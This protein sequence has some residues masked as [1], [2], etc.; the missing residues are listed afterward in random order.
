[1]YI[2]LLLSKVFYKYWFRTCWF[3]DLVKFFHPWWF[4]LV[5]LSVIEIRVLKSEIILIDL[6]F[7]FL[8]Y[9]FLLHMF[10]SSAFWCIFVHICDSFIF[11]RNDSLSLVTLFALKST[12]SDFNI[13][14]PVFFWLVFVW[15]ISFH[16]F[17]FNL[18]ILL[19]LKQVS[20]GQ[21]PV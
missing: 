11:L 18:P 19:Y 6:S 12:Q 16:P 13:G 9:Q 21:P 20:C 10:C 15:Y 8:F 2:L 5:V 3:N 4:C 14:T 1:M 17:T 7:S